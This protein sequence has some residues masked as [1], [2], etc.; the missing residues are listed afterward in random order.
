MLYR[1]IPICLLFVI[2]CSTTFA[3]ATPDTTSELNTTSATATLPTYYGNKSNSGGVHF[4]Y[5]IDLGYAGSSTSAGTIKAKGGAFY[6]GGDFGI[7]ISLPCRNEN[8][9]NFLFVSVAANEYNIK[10]KYT[11]D[12]GKAQ[13]YQR[14]YTLL[15]LPLSYMNM[16]YGSGGAGVGFYW[17]LGI[18]T[19]YMYQVKDEDRKVTSHYTNI[20]LEPF[21][22]LGF[23]VPFVLRN[24]RSHSDVGGGRA[25]M[26]LY[27]GYDAMNLA[28]DSGV[29]VTGYTIA[30]KWT[31]L[32]M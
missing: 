1:H 17:Q 19:D 4:F 16:S 6:Y 29:T 10:Y 2:C 26:G 9:S 31:Y 23:S 30:V 5:G 7:K 22:S 15:K 11:D 27:G 20:F 28:K 21:A 32:F 18:N 12:L 14:K 3:M 24:R 13:S 8:K 25:L